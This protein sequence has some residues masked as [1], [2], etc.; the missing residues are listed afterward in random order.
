MEAKIEGDLLI[1][2]IPINK[3]LVPS[4]RSGNTRII[5]SSHGNQ[6]TDVP[7]DSKGT[8]QI[9][10]GLNAFTYSDDV[11]IVEKL[12]RDRPKKLSAKRRK[13]IAEHNRQISEQVSSGQ[14]GDS[15]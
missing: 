2:K 10:I 5:A 6:K 8:L 7:V 9:Y 13:E 4:K 3:P 1:V 11:N 14:K 12:R 15:T